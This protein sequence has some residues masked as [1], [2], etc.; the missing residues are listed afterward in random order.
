MKFEK[1]VLDY[2][3]KDVV[4]YEVFS[5]NEITLN[6][7]NVNKKIKGIDWGDSLK[8]HLKR[9]RHDID[10]KYGNGNFVTVIKKG[11]E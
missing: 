1:L 7:K 10:F 2:L 3:M 11:D 4:E 8:E 6:L 9:Y 5:N